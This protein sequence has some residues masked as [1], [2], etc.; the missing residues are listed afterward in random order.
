MWVDNIQVGIDLATS[1]TILIAV[2]TF[3]AN[4]IKERKIGVADSARSTIIENI[5]ISITDMAKSFNSFVMLN[6]SIEKKID[7]PLSQGAE[8]F[9]EYLKVEKKAAKEIVELF[10]KSIS[11]MGEFYEKGEMLKYTIFPSLYSIGDESEAVNII[12]KEISDVMDS[13]NESN[14][15]Y[16]SYLESV[17]ALSAGLEQFRDEGSDISYSKIANDLSRVVDD[18]DHFLFLKAF[19]KDEKVD[20]FKASIAKSIA[21]MTEDEKKIRV[22]LIETLLSLMEANPELVIAH[23][24]ESL[25]FKLQ[26]NRTQCK[27]FLITLSAVSSKMQQRS[28]NFSVKKA[29]EDLSSEKYFD[30]RGTIR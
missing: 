16:L 27:E 11:A 26:E 25:S 19:I 20:S 24:L 12:K 6:T 17:L 2:G 18:S 30:T 4:S 8:Y 14:R 29:Y 7:I 9:A 10:R 3:W 15:S 23:A 5:N 13:Y 28:G 22:S 21:D 1:V